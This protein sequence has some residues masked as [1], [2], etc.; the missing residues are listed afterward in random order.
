MQTASSQ[1]AVAHTGFGLAWLGFT[2]RHAQQSTASDW[3]QQLMQ[4]QHVPCAIA[5]ASAHGTTLGELLVLH[6]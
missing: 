1:E 3:S 2:P 6:T 5:R 4:Q